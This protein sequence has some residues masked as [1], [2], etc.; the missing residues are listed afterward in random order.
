MLA[1]RVLQAAKVQDYEIE[2]SVE[3][4]TRN[5]GYNINICSYEAS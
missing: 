2:I 4:K 5:P 3:Q 1:L